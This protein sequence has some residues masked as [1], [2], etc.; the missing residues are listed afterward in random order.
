MEC[1]TDTTSDHWHLSKR[2]PGAKICYACYKKAKI[3]EAK[4]AGMTCGECGTDTA[5][6]WL[7]S[8]LDPGAKICNACYH[9][10]RRGKKKAE[11]NREL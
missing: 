10:A 4:A 9:K 6:Q 5:S 7:N 3:S 2:K 11:T 1:G 8:K